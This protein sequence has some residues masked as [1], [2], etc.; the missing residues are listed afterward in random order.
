MIAIRHKADDR[1]ESKIRTMYQKC[2]G[3]SSKIY[4]K[5][6]KSLSED[7]R[8]FVGSSL[9]VRREFAGRLAGGSSREKSTYQTEIACLNHS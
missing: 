4:W 7:H 3:S 6:I 8:E 1:P 5:I 2:V 9:R